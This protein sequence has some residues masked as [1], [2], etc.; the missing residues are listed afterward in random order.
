MKVAIMQPTY[1]PWIGYFDLMDQVDLFVLLD[2]VQFAKRSWQQRN[3]YKTPDGLKWLT[4][5]VLV[6]GR[7]HQLILQVEIAD[8]DFWKKHLRSIE[9]NYQKAPF[10]GRY[11]PDLYSLFESN[12]P[13]RY[14]VDVNIAC[15]RW[16]SRHF[17]IETPLIRASELEGIE[18]KR[19]SLLANIAHRIGASEYLSPFGSACYLLKEVNE[20]H[21]KGIRVFF[22]NYSHLT[23]RQLFGSFIPYASALDL[24]MNEGPESIAIIRQGRGKPFSVEEMKERF[25]EGMLKERLYDDQNW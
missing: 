5:P 18:G 15:I 16:L 25:L 17:G 20:F 24:L 4:V 9:I 3:R 23:Y 19:S 11:F 2:N 13:W 7:Y 10:F 21:R 8:P 6:K 12:A 1:L 22:Q 14:L